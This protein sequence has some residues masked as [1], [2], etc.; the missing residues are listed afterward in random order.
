MNI[1][2]EWPADINRN[3]W[4]T[5]VWNA[6]PTSSESAKKMMHRG[7]T[8]REVAHAMGWVDWAFQSGVSAGT[9]PTLS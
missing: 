6:R 7:L 9:P 4:P 2:L 5:S 1:Q 8:L 3:R